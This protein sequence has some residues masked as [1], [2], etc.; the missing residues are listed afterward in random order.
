MKC[1]G[2]EKL[3]DYLDGRL[4]ASDASF[5]ESHISAGCRR[6]EAD[7]DWYQTLKTL[8]ASDES[9]E[10]PPWVLKKAVNLFDDV[11]QKGGLAKRA[12]R[13]IAALVFDSLAQPATAGVRSSG[14]EGR[15]VLYRA[16]DYSIDI[17]VSTGD[18]GWKMTGQILRNDERRFESVKDLPLTVSKQ[19]R[20]VRESVT[21]EMGEFSI[22]GTSFGRFDVEVSTPDGPIAVEGLRVVAS[23]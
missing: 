20:V 1:P 15:Q 10:P 21:N 12:R 13:I 22:E 2:F 18:P 11:R 19:G 9:I 8:T 5:V 23:R 16:G 14:T 3:L 17:Q 4:P 7:R 6:C